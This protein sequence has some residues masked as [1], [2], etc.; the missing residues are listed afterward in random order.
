MTPEQVAEAKRL[1]IDWKVTSLLSWRSAVTNGPELTDK[2]PLRETY[3]GRW[4]QLPPLQKVGL[5]VV[6]GFW[7]LFIAT[8]VFSGGR[9]EGRTI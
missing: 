2:D 6:L 9:A 8:L 7:C 5:I 1:I 4:A 3:E